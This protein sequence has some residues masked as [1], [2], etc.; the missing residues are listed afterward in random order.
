MTFDASGFETAYDAW[1]L[2]EA[3][4]ACERFRSTHYIVLT[5]LTQGSGLIMRQF[6]L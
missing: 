2:S 4:E 3:V 5:K 1:V 6:I